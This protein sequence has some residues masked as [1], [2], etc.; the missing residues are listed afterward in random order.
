MRRRLLIILISIAVIVVTASVAAWI[1]FRSPTLT[2]TVLNLANVQSNTNT[3]GIPVNTNT[4]DPAAEAAAAEAAAINFTSRNFIETYGSYNNQNNFSHVT[5]AKKW[6]TASFS[7]FL[8]QEV[9]RQRVGLA[10]T[11]Y[12]EYLTT[13]LVFTVTAKSNTTAAVT[14]STQR[15][16]IKDGKTTTYYQDLLLDLLKVDGSWKVNAASWKAVQ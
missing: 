7:K 13:A 12:H 8:D 9:A 3:G 1:I 10:T 2:N 14:V 6:T 4:T 5:E 16:E 15:Q 11:P